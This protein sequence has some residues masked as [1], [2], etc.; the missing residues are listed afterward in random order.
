MG[1]NNQVPPRIALTSSISPSRYYDIDARGRLKVAYGSVRVC[2]RGY[3]EGIART[4]FDL[5]FAVRKMGNQMTR[6]GNASHKKAESATVAGNTQT[7]SITAKN[8]SGKSEP[9]HD[10]HMQ[11]FPIES[12]AK[13][14]LFGNF[15]IDCSVFHGYP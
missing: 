6:V 11:F 8:A 15:R 7:A 12:L 4:G 1:M 3:V 10:S 13:V 9:E 14:C 2:Y 5:V